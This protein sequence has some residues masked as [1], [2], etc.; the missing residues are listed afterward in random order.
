MADLVFVLQCQDSLVQF[1]SFLSQQLSLDEIN[2][3]LPFMDEL[4][5]TY[6]IPPDVAFALWRSNYMSGIKVN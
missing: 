5:L 2:K 1:I 3:R 4:L 6:H